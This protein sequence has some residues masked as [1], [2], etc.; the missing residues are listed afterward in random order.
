[1]LRYFRIP[2]LLFL[3]GSVWLTIPTADAQETG[4]QFE[5]SC[6]LDPLL[7]LGELWSVKPD[8]LEKLFKAGDFS[9]NPY[10]QMMTREDSSDQR[11]VFSRKL[12]SNVTCTMTSFGGRLPVERARID[13][14]DDQAERIMIVFHDEKAPPLSSEAYANLHKTAVETL[15][16]LFSSEPVP[17]RY[18]HDP[19]KTQAEMQG[20]GF[21]TRLAPAVLTKAEGFKWETK[22]YI[23]LLDYNVHPTSPKELPDRP[24]IRLRFVPPDLSGDLLLEEFIHES[25]QGLLNCSLDPLLSVPAVWKMTPAEMTR[26][27]S[28]PP[29][30][31]KEAGDDQNP[32]FKWLTE[33][34][35]RAL[36][37]R[38]Q[39]SNQHVDL[40][41]WNGKIEAQEA[42]VDFSNGR[43]SEV[44]FSLYNRGDSGEIDPAEFKELFLNCGRSLSETLGVR[45]TPRRP[46]TKTGIDIKGYQWQG[47]VGVAVLEYNPEA[48]DADSPD[49]QYLRL[50]LSP[51]EIAR[52]GVRLI[53][54]PA[55]VKRDQDSGNILIPEIPMVDQGAKG[56]CVVAACQ[57]LFEYYR[58]PIDQHQLAPLFRSTAQRGTRLDDM[59]G[60]LERISH[61]FHIR[62]T[63]LRA[64]TQY[65]FQQVIKTNVDQGIPLLWALLVGIF[66]EEPPLTNQ[67]GGG[68]MRLIIGYNFD[69]GH[70]I[71]SDTWGLGH[72]EKRMRLD[73]AFKAQSKLF[74]VEP[75][76]R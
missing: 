43:I 14:A 26:T 13:F 74:R 64:R 53:Q 76:M 4:N 28:P 65:D 2:F 67:T 40:R 46:D 35:N 68:H 37:Y 12:Y 72:E 73:Y 36:F 58:V 54:L 34:K 20:A 10:F 59:E 44:I 24:L 69:T 18:A 19:R 45:A 52:Q 32:Y 66:P 11:A 75:T 1:M 38:K 27:F 7:E 39:F 6:E 30:Y 25:R 63:P 55:N 22:N 62:F 56:Y 23:A 5:V 3:F 33:S 21:N 42:I 70:V 49:P 50:R 29:A 60:S 51:K 15:N 57:R 71:F 61:K 48:M 47:K 16:G 41:L 8:Q 9:V 17:H 31:A